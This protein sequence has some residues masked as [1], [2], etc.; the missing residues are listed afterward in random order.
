MLSNQAQ[1]RPATI[2]CIYQNMG[3]S[4]MRDDLAIVV[5]AQFLVYAV[6]WAG[7]ACVDK[8]RRVSSTY[9]ALYALFQA[10]SIALFALSVTWSSK[11]FGALSL[12]LAIGGYALSNAGVDHF[13]NERV[14]YA[15]I[16]ICLVAFFSTVALNPLSLLREQAAQV[17]SL[18][19]SA[20]AFCTIGAALFARPLRREFGTAGLIALLPSILYALLLAVKTI[21]F[22]IGT[23]VSKTD[24]PSSESRLGLFV[25]VISVAGAVNIS[26]LGL[27]VSRLLKSMKKVAT[28]D[29][30]TGLLNRFE[31]ARILRGEWARH[32]RSGKVLGLAFVDIDHFKRINDLGGHKQGDEVL[33]TTAALLNRELRT[34]DIVG[35][36]GGE[37]FLIILPETS[38]QGAVAVMMRLHQALQLDKVEVP[39]GCEPLTI[40]VGVSSSEGASTR[41]GV[42]ELIAQ[43]DQAMYRAKSSGRNRTVIH[44]M[45]ATWV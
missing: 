30:L 40:S 35:R 38:A 37:E 14:R 33:R 26:F 4:H 9:W 11:S 1:G 25:F 29:S 19:G 7:I 31:T 24:L 13:L 2:N 21:L 12:L 15:W 32:E 22:F 3:I 39:A 17:L 27:Y 43:A 5:G 18:N 8:P 45:S 6:A 36:W 10:L 44:E 23:G 34:S 28:T 16:W 41:N 20:V 42:D